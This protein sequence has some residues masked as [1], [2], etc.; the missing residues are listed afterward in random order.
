[1]ALAGP[2]DTRMGADIWRGRKDRTGAA[3]LEARHSN[4]QV[5]AP[6]G[7]RG[8]S[9]L[10]E[11]IRRG[12]GSLRGAWDNQREVEVQPPADRSLRPHRLILIT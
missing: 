10:E 6:L 5:V 8:R 12:R 9:P 1:M 2:Q 3:L 4:L 7:P 11:D